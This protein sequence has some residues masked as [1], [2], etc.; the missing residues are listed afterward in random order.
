V[1]TPQPGTGCQTQNPQFTNPTQNDFSLLSGSSCIENGFDGYDIGACFYTEI[2]ESPKL[3]E[4][5]QHESDSSQIHMRWVNPDSTTLGNILDSVV[6][7]KIWRNDSLIAE[8]LN[9]TNQDTL[10]YSD[11]L[12][13]PDFFRYQIAVTD[14]NGTTGRN[15]YS[16]EM[17]LG[18]AIGGIVIWDLDRT[19]ISGQEITNALNSVGYDGN[20]YK[21]NYSARYPLES[22]V[23]AVFVCLGVYDKNHILSV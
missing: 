12:A 15:I 10:V 21:T 14:T 13:R 3:F 23:K 17:L 18:G 11:V 7:V 4:L 5:V 20:I 8:I 6:S 9:N 19:P 1:F 22:T 16:S 2:P